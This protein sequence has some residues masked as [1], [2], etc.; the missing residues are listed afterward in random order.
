MV[1]KPISAQIMLKEIPLSKQIEKSTLVFEGKVLSKKSFWDVNH[2]KIYTVNTVEVHKVFKGDFLTT[3]DIITLGGVTDSEAQM[4][5]PSL[6]LYKGDLGVFTL[7]EGNVLLDAAAVPK[8]RYMPYGSSQAFYKY[9]VNTNEASNIFITKNGITDS[10]YN[11]IKS[12]T[13]ADYIEVAPFD[14]QSKVNVSGKVNNALAIAITGFSPAVST[15]GTKSVLTIT[16]SGFGTVKGK[17]GF[18][19]AE[20]AGSS[21]IDAL[22]S[23]V[24]TWDD[25]QVTVEIPSKAGTGKIRITHDDNSTL[26]S[27]TNLTVNYSQITV[28]SDNLNTGIDVAYPTQHVDD[29]GS[30]GYTWQM[31]TAFNAVTGAKAPF[32]RALETWRCESKINWFLDEANMVS[33]TA[34]QHQSVSD[35]MNVITF[36]NSSSGNPDDDLPDTVLGRRTTYFVPCLVNGDTDLRWY[37]REFDVV[38]DD[39]SVWNFSTN[40]PTVLQLDFES[41]ALHELGHCHQLDHVID[42][43]DSM[44]YSISKG[45]SNRVLNTQNKTI[46]AIIQARS[47]GTPVCSQSLMQNYAGICNLGVEEDELNAS[48]KLYPNP[49]KDNLFIENNGLVAL[50]KIVIYDLSGRCIFKQDM[51]NASRVTTINLNSV[52]KGIY[53]VNIHSDTTSITKRMVLE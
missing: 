30:G 21:Y 40:T 5:S 47:I 41:V 35:N 43:N 17:V 1:S 50:E 4:V 24:L 29:N 37:I 12:I 2:E 16:G 48:V 25:E 49:T 36:D 14:V 18:S 3:V 23:Q 44:H 52:S 20:N 45:E 8:K 9:D 28:V 26:A 19:N 11:E 42:T 22:D 38:F 32:L 33:A 53:F 10:F 27:N 6:E 7:N 46:A 39:E 51:S 13:K 15:A 34:A 31:T